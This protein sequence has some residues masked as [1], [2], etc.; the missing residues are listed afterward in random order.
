MQNW[1]VSFFASENHLKQRR[2]CQTGNSPRTKSTPCSVWRKQSSGMV[3]TGRQRKSWWTQISEMNNTR[4]HA[5][6]CL[7]E[8]IPFSERNL[9]F[10]IA[11]LSF[12]FETDWCYHRECQIS[13]KD[14]T[15]NLWAIFRRDFF[16]TFRLRRKNSS[17]R[18][19]KILRYIELGWVHLEVTHR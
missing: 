13:K 1:R 11:S 15:W 4:N 8:I 6:F 17:K 14:W 9:Y 10:L 16:K 12:D 5:T 19:N 3:A 7:D 18:E 2:L